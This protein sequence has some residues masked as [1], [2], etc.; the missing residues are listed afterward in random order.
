MKSE[1][2]KLKHTFL[3]GRE[4]TKVITAMRSFGKTYCPFGL[5]MSEQTYMR[6]KVNIVK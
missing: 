2:K 5:F 4:D 3:I 1:Y 6:L